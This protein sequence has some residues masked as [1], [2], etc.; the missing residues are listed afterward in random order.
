M[1][2]MLSTGGTS[3]FALQCVWFLAP[4]FWGD[5]VCA[6]LVMQARPEHGHGGGGQVF[7]LLLKS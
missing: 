7:F 4:G 6:S 1:D 3:S 2:L 5:T